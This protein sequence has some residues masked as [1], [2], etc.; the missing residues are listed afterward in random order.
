MDANQIKAEL[1]DR[2]IEFK[3]KDTP[4]KLLRTLNE[5]REAAGEEPATLG[6]EKKVSG[7]TKAPE[8][9]ANPTKK[10]TPPPRDPREPTG[11]GIKVD[12]ANRVPDYT[13]PP[14]PNPVKGRTYPGGAEEYKSIKKVP[15]KTQT[16]TM[17][18]NVRHDGPIFIKDTEYE[19]SVEMATIFIEEGWAE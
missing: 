19:V 7:Q 9:K 11:N 5:A 8:P 2:G 6:K 15:G 16:I 1:K 4:E 13:P 12:P 18:S 3:V 17:L 14:M 10:N